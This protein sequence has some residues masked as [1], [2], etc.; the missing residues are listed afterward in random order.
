MNSHHEL[1][2]LRHS[3]GKPLSAA[4]VF[5]L[6]FHVGSYHYN[7]SENTCVARLHLPLVARF[8][9]SDRMNGNVNV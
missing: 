5:V 6:E 3:E 4:G 9:D 8:L 7:T 2:W 1:A